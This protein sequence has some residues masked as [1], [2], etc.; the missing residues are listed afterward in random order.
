VRRAGDELPG[1][2]QWEANARAQAAE[3]GELPEGAVLDAAAGL[4]RY[5]AEGA[6]ALSL[7]RHGRLAPGPLR[8]IKS[9]LLKKSGLLTR[10]RGGE[11]F[12]DLG[13]L[14]ALKDF[15]TCA[16]RPGRPPGVRARGIPRH[17]PIRSWLTL[18]PSTEAIHGP[19][20]RPDRPHAYPPPSR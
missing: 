5:A 3:P 11:T 9:G 16:L 8:E 17:R 19:V 14:A 1:R 15:C 4:T 2:E 10:H 6:F 20:R 12:A 18:D 7:M 13:D